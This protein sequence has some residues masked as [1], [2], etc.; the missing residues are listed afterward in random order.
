MCSSA[1]A[2][3]YRSLKGQGASLAEL[4]STSAFA[5]LGYALVATRNV[6]P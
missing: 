1:A 4:Q 2:N 6:V 5:R 3:T